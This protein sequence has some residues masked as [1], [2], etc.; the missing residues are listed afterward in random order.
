MPDDYPTFI[1]DEP[2]PSDEFG[3]HKRVAEALA[4]AVVRDGRLKVVGLIGGWGSGKSTV[5]SLMTG[6]LKQKATA[7]LFNYDAWQHQSDPPRRAFLD[8]LLAFLG[9]EAGL[10]ALS[11]DGETWEQRAEHLNNQVE[12]SD[13]KSNP[14]IT[15]SGAAIIASLIFFPLGIRLIGEGSIP[16]ENRNDLLYIAVFVLGWALVFMPA[17]MTFLI[18]MS[19]R[20]PKLWL[21][22]DYWTKHR[23]SKADRSI[24]ALIANRQLETTTQIK[25]KTPEPTALEFQQVMADIFDDISDQTKRLVIVIDNL[26]RLPATEAIALWSTIRGMF[27]GRH[28]S[29]P[30]RGHLPVILLPIDA[31]AMNKL[32]KNSKAQDEGIGRSFMEKTFDLTFAVPAPV[33]SRWRL[34]TDIQIDK[35]FAD[36]ISARDKHG[37]KMIIDDGVV[38]G[39][40]EVTPRAINTALNSVA[41]L[42]MQW[43]GD[44]ISVAA[45]AYYV[46]HRPA[47]D[48]LGIVEAMGKAIGTI[49]DLDTDWAKAIAAIHFGVPKADVLQLT[50]V[51]PIRDAIKAQDVDAFRSLA[52]VPG[53]DRYLGIALNEMTTD[54]SSLSVPS[55]AVLLNSL[56][57]NASSWVEVAWEKLRALFLLSGQIGTVD[58]DGAAISHLTRYTPDA[59]RGAFIVGAWAKLAETAN[60]DFAEATAPF[61]GALETV[62]QEAK[63]ESL[64]LKPMGISTPRA[65]CR[66]LAAPL[67]KELLLK[68]TAEGAPEEVAR[69][70]G[71]MVS[72]PLESVGVVAAV[73]NLVARFESDF[74]WEPLV[75]AVRSQIMSG[76]AGAAEKANECLGLLAEPSQ[77]A[78]DALGTLYGEG[79][80]QNRF[81]EAV[82]SSSLAIPKIIAAFV[83]AD[84]V[85]QSPPG[86]WDALL[87]ANP[88]LAIEVIREFGEFGWT[89]DLGYIVD[90]K[91]GQDDAT[92]LLQKIA[93]ALPGLYGFAKLDYEHLTKNFDAYLDLVA[94]S[95]AG[96]FWFNVVEQP[97]FWVEVRSRDLQSIAPFL[98]RLVE[99]Q[100]TSH[101]ATRE[102]R[103]LVDAF[104]AAHWE[105]A[106]REGAEP[107]LLGMRVSAVTGKVFNRSVSDGLAQVGRDV[108]QAADPEALNRWFSLL[109]HLRAHSRP[110]LY[111]VVRDR[112]AEPGGV[113]DPLKVLSAGPPEM[114]DEGSFRIAADRLVR[115]TLFRLLD[116]PN[117]RDWVTANPAA[118]REWV[119]GSYNSTRDELRAKLVDMDDYGREKIT[120]LGL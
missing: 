72:D 84:E 99:E 80:L 111:R 64:D 70:A 109:S 120:Q 86:G 25:R 20:D 66:L 13:T 101:L 93:E 44:D 45:M 24:F 67:D 91:K 22:S 83:A 97:E 51:G 43:R 94:G 6:L 52:Q 69:Y 95:E 5:V 57:P 17:L 117:G 58:V 96:A 61:R 28:R 63:R 10:S 7:H 21:K 75:E 110:P 114:F 27:L 119:S 81:N 90:L 55:A 60:A 16:F 46:I 8:S 11:P 92:P 49:D 89:F 12:K 98:H 103:V 9:S 34:Y 26:D 71:T 33:G 54:P 40:F 42:W 77:T 68:I 116:D 73:R 59:S 107:Y 78:R 100:S 37:V 118:V 39:T 53:F 30:K 1:I 62:F 106:V 79:S 4:E 32:Y 3:T 115:F 104:D 76:E 65:F 15:G 74:P 36:L 105:R 50:L 19:W 18:Y 88:S 31:D 112:L 108:L 2:A 23:K 14:R 85:P 113:S 56:M 29:G 102:V 48:K 35:V 82:S 38:A 47:I 41:T 87:E